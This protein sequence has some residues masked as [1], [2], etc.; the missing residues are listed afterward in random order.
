[1]TEP[2][3]NP[4]TNAVTPNS[5]FVY[6]FAYDNRYT[7]FIAAWIFYITDHHSRTPKSC[8]FSIYVRKRVVT[9]KTVFVSKHI[10]SIKYRLYWRYFMCLDCHFCSAFCS[11]T[12]QNS[13]TSFCS[14]ARTKTVSSRTM[15]CVWLVGSFW[16]IIRNYIVFT[17]F[18]Q[19][20]HRYSGFVST[21]LQCFSTTS[22]LFFV[23]CGKHSPVTPPRAYMA[24]VV[25]EN[26]LVRYSR[27]SIRLIIRGSGCYIWT[28][29][30]GSVFLV[31]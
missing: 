14:N 17:H 30:F 16:H 2:F 21:V 25:V 20:G 10:Y 23:E 19:V 22:P 28:M 9:M 18:T 7:W 13:S 8:T 26:P 4:T 3:V 15:S 31:K 5:T 24:V 1:M 11:S 6:F 27:A 29:V 12:L